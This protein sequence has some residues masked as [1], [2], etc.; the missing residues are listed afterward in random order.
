MPL[1]N[2]S[3][4]LHT[5]N[6]NGIFTATKECY[7]GGCQT[8]SEAGNDI[9]INGTAVF[10]GKSP[11]SPSVYNPIPFIRLKA[12]DIVSCTTYQHPYLHIYD[13]A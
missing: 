9:L 6:T 13:I 1:L 7:L 3:N 10:H 8:T 5:F 2:Y 11:T 4:P 12:G